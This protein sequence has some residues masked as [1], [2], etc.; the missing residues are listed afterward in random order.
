MTSKLVVKE[1]LTAEGKNPFRTWL[2]TLDM[3]VSQRIQAR[4][5][6]LETGNLGDV[7]GL[8][9]GIFEARIAFG[10]GYRIYFGRDE[11]T[12]VLILLGGDKSHQSKDILRARYYWVDYLERR[13]V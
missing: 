11:L 12:S 5:L 4:I 2:S 1:Y 8:R 6:R 13:N 9:G 10:P 7:K 3:A